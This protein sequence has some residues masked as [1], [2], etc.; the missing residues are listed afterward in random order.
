[1]NFRRM[2]SMKIIRE[3]FLIIG[4]LFTTPTA[5][6]AQTL[7]SVVPDT[8][9]QGE[10]LAVTITGQNTNFT[11]GSGTTGVWFS[12]G[13]PTVNIFAT[14]F[15]PSSD[16]LLSADFDIPGDAAV[17]LWNMNVQDDIDGT[18]T[19]ADGFTITLRPVITLYVDNDAANDPGSGDPCVSDPNEDGSSQHPFDAIQEAIDAAFDGDTV[20]VLQG[21]YTGS[22]NR[23]IDFGGKALTVRS[24]DPNDS[25]VVA[26]TII[27]C[28]G[29]ESEPHRG[30]Y[31][32]DG[33]DPNSALDGFTIINGYAASG[34]PGS[35]CGGAVY[36][37][38]GIPTISNCVFSRNSAYIG[39]GIYSVYSDLMLTN[40]AFTQ[41]LTPSDGYSEGVY[42]YAG[43]LTL[44]NCSF[45]GNSGGGVYSDGS[46]GGENLVVSNCSF[47][48]NSGGGVYS[49]GS[50]SGR[51]VVVSNCTFSGNG[52]SGIRLGARD[53]VLITNCLFTGNSSAAINGAVVSLEIA[54]SIVVNNG[55]WGTGG[56][57][58][59]GSDN[60]T[61]RN[62]LIAGNYSFE[63]AGG[64]YVHGTATITNCTITGNFAE[65]MGGGIELSQDSNLL[66]SNCILWDNAAPV[67][68]NEIHILRNSELTISYSDIQDGLSSIHAGI[69]ST[70]NWGIG[71]IDV[72]PDFNSPGYWDWGDW[73]DGDYHLLADS[74]CI[75][76]GDP[77][78]VT[79]GNDFDI[80]GNPRV[81]GGRIDM[82]FAEYN[83][84]K[85]PDFDGDKIVNF[86]D[87]AILASYWLE[88]SCSW[89]DW[90]QGSDLDESGVVDFHDQRIFVDHWLEEEHI[91]FHYSPLDTDPC[92]PT[93]GEWAFGEP[94][95][96]GGTQ[97]GNPDPSKGYTSSNV[98]GVNLN[99]DY[100]HTTTGGPY[101]VT[102]GPFDCSLYKNVSLKFARWLNTDEPAYVESTVEVSNDGTSWAIVWEHTERAEITDDSWRMVKYDISSVADEQATVYIRWGY[103]ILP[104]AY[105]YSGWNIDDI[106][107]WGNPM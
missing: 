59:C 1:M 40:C 62:S 79:D 98:Y 27:D 48:G 44:I 90:C 65:L 81:I 99:G 68:G 41:N 52:G 97:H 75:D 43:N 104:E 42:H 95:G 80:D 38:Y 51:N 74:P 16:T 50:P 19:L 23:D 60:T 10:S 72:N 18:L 20:I 100:D 34:I 96:E 21:T 3:Y 36:N 53:S 102:A 39:S 91:R 106:E 5:L 47:T 29:T 93:S 26:A 17:G 32:H 69:G 22:G 63:D 30:F 105:P 64:I 70:V 94:N 11:Q 49:S 85:F 35:P 89:P 28:N 101:Y 55:G 86:V 92:W 25:N 13:S 78:Y 7:T 107:F 61:I 87:F 57:I 37:S 71:N 103:E 83:P 67:L 77:N 12:Q 14:S 76:A 31:F 4:L 56:G 9:Q 66:L 6:I 73:V 82:G 33:E 24:I 2:I 54:N 45:T 84:G 88:Y 8:A 58:Y 15:L 46:P